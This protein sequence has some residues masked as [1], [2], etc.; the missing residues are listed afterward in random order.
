M[1]REQQEEQ[2]PAKSGGRR[3]QPS[4]SEV[5]QRRRDKGLAERSEVLRGSVAIR[6]SI[7]GKDLPS[8]ARYL[9]N[10]VRYFASPLEPYASR[11]T[12]KKA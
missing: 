10:V 4:G 11:T 3:G 6:T 8:A 7:E 5:P 12:R 1:P 9:P 2:R